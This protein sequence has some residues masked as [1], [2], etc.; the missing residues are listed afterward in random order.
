MRIGKLVFGTYKLDWCKIPRK[1]WELYKA[2]YGTQLKSL[3]Y[4]TRVI[5]FAKRT[6]QERK[7]TSY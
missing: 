3:R 5:W 4:K 1:D 6:Q 2:P 7:P